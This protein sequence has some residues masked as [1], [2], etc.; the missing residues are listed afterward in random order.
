VHMLVLQ[1]ALFGVVNSLQFSAMNTLTLADLEGE[2]ASSGNS[3]LSVVMQLSMS[4]GVAA[5]AALL[6]AFAP[7]PGGQVG[8]VGSPILLLAFQRTYLC[9]GVLSMLASLVFLQLAPEDGAT[10]RRAVGPID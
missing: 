6:T 1:L 5:G 4:L 7:Q 3:L 8:E 2:T 10:L 9:V